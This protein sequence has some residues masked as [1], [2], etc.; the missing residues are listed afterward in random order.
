MRTRRLTRTIAVSTAA[1]ALAAVP[2]TAAMAD[3]ATSTIDYG[4]VTGSHADSG[5]LNGWA[6]PSP[7]GFTI[8]VLAQDQLRI[9]NR[10]D[11]STSTQ[12]FSHSSLSSP[13][14]AT[15]VGEPASGADE[16]EISVTFSLESADGGYQEGL[17]L[18]LSLDSAPHQTTR[19]GG[20]V[21]M[22]HRDNALYVGSFWY[23]PTAPDN[24][25]NPP[26]TPGPYS[27]AAL[28]WS[29]AV[30]QPLDPAGTYTITLDGKYVDGLG[31]DNTL[32]DEV[33]ITIADASGTVIET[34]DAGSWEGQA[35]ATG[36]STAREVTALTFYSGRN[37]SSANAVGGGAVFY[38][39]PAQAS[40]GSTGFL[41]GPLEVTTGSEPEPEPE[42][43]PTPTPSPTPGPED[44]PR[45]TTTPP[46]PPTSTEVLAMTPLVSHTNGGVVPASSTITLELGPDW[47]YEWLY[48]VFYS[49]PTVVGWVQADAAGT[50]SIA[51]PS[52]L[53]PGAHTLALLDEDGDLVATVSLEIA[54]AAD[55]TE[56][57]LAD[58]GI[59]REAVAPAVAASALLVIAG[60]LLAGYGARRRQLL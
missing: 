10:R 58:T 49:E 44:K 28:Y 57:E 48:A 1:A 19:A 33:T 2:L 36:A 38:P 4:D 53:S 22:V 14:L 46:V 18:A 17:S 12:F 13:V 20:T 42:V 43:T 34:L 32:N 31:E 5:V 39:A 8:D 45:P 7:A 52:G 35:A 27:G 11:G 54:A 55:G 6:L 41:V 25:A 59:P 26:V 60:L 24:A 16:S 21:Y 56:D 29:E 9:L 50:F 47:A 15:T 37:T 40:A 51:V 23:D 3:V 30:S